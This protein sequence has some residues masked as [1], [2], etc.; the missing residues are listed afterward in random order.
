MPKLRATF[1]LR[2][3][4]R[5]DG[6]VNHT[7]ARIGGSLGCDGG[8]FIGKGKVPALSANGATIDGVVFLRDGFRACGKVELSFA[9]IGGNLSCDSGRFVSRKLIP[10]LDAKGA[11]IQGMV[12]FVDSFSAGGGVAFV[13]ATIGGN[14]VCGDALFSSEVGW[15]RSPL[16]GLQ[17]SALTARSAKIHGSAFL[18]RF[19]AKGGVDLTGATIDGSLEC[20]WSEFIGEGKLLALNANCA[21]VLG[22]VF[23]RNSFKAQGGVDLILATIGGNLVC[24]NGAKF[25]GEIINGK[26]ERLAISASGAK[27]DGNVFFRATTKTEPGLQ[28]DG[29]VRFAHAVGG[30]FEWQDIESH[31]KASLDLRFTKIGLLLNEEQSWPSKGNVKLDGFVYD[32]F[33]DQAPN[34]KVQLNW[35]HL[36]PKKPFSSPPYEQLAK[37]LKSSG[38]E[39]E[40][41]EVLIAKQDDLR[42]Y[43]D[44]GWWAKFAILLLGFSIRHGYKPRRALFGMLIFILFGTIAFQA[45]YWCHLLTRSNNLANVP[46]ARADYPKFQ[47]FV[48]SLDTFLPIVDLNQKGYWLPNANHGDNV[49][50]GVRF[51][52]GGLLRIYFWV[53]IIFGWILTTLWV[54]G[55]TGLVRRLN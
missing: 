55:F 15:K 47:A 40:A 24:E 43:G 7:T 48:Y 28:V 9:K 8:R 6:G 49:I 33:D 32:Q 34:A 36:Q 50:P 2:D 4:F 41:T 39:S 11:K 13:G 26:E 35:L 22:N 51:R 20:D 12:S 54:A 46:I 1:F 52:W 10:A 29:T 45:G 3:G 31:E 21:K 18:R 42:R 23:L 38:H 5:A 16:V 25:V 53:H 19:K 14:L 37:V 30:N 44:L 27:V 17:M